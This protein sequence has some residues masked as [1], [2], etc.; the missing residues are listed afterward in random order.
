M[1]VS[2]PRGWREVMLGDVTVCLD[3]RRVPLNNEER[4]KM[5]GTIPYYGANGQ[6][7]T[8]NKHIFDEELLLLAEDGGSWGFNQNCAYI[9]KGKSWVNNHAHV[10]RMKEIIDISYLMHFLN[11][12]DLDRFISGTTRGKL[13]QSVMKKIPVTLPPLQVQKK[14]VSTL[15]KAEQ[16]REL[17]KEA[18]ELTKDFLKAVFLEMFA[19][20]IANE[21]C[22]I[23]LEEITTRITD[24]EH[25]TPKRVD[26]GIYLLSAR[27]I[28]NHDISLEDVDFIDDEEFQRISRRIKPQ[29]GDVL[30]SCSGSV[31]RV[32]RVKED[33]KFQLVRSVALIR[34]DLSKLNPIYLEYF[35]ETEY[36]QRQILRSINQ[37]N[38]ANLFQG[39]IRKLKVYL[40][41]MELQD[42]F[43]SIVEKTEMLKG[44]QYQSKKLLSNLFNSLTQRAF[45]G[46]IAC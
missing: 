25:D 29:L 1:N 39:Q 27:N 46:E 44:F 36:M 43:A 8:I 4:S 24:G 20:D 33:F 30:V 26:K 19:K 3:E 12:H 9:I 16:A 14:I 38:Q 32:T 15:K 42:K 18:G 35:I 7:D 40:P 11:Y 6:V 22:H 21:S 13:N 31:G 23:P 28:L 41:P 45:K 34:S 10:L 2:L 37:S 5:Q 17:R